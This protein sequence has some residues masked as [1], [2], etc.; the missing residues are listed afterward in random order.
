MVSPRPVNRLHPTLPSMDHHYM[1]Y[2]HVRVML[3][4][5][6]ARGTLDPEYRPWDAPVPLR[7]RHSPCC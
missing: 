5:H 7:S 2:G 1:P 4:R 3:Q 6:A